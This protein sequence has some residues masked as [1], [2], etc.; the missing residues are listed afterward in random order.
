MDVQYAISYCLYKSFLIKQ[1]ITK[2]VTQQI[3]TYTHPFILDYIAGKQSPQTVRNM[4]VL[5]DLGSWV[6]GYPTN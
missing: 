6:G 5:F 2:Q 1:L 3:R 4:T